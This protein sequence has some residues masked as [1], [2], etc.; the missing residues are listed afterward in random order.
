M[1][2]FVIV[3]IMIALVLF[4]P[5]VYMMGI[6]RGIAAAKSEGMEGGLPSTQP[7]AKCTTC[8]KVKYCMNPS[9]SMQV[10]C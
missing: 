6:A 4:M 7:V 10:F 2:S 9:P 5:A 8:A 3:I 1:C